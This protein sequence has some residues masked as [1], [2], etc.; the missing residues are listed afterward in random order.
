[1]F[2]Y[3]NV[4]PFKKKWLILFIHVRKSGKTFKNAGTLK[5]KNAE[6]TDF[7]NLHVHKSGII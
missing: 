3:K 6:M 4:I 1:M 7:L 5:K 2:M